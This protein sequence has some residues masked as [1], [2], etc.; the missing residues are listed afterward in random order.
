MSWRPWR[1]SCLTSTTMGETARWST[2]ASAGSASRPSSPTVWAGCATTVSSECVSNVALSPS[3][4]A[5][6]ERERL[7]LFFILAF[8]VFHHNVARYFRYFFSVIPFFRA[9][10]PGIFEKHSC[11][12]HWLKVTVQDQVVH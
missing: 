3:Q 10:L 4:G 1:R 7:A 2:C 11:L 9:G 12:I 8:I 6:A 5:A